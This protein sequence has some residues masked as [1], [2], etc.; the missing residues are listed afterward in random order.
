MRF[1]RTKFLLNL[2]TLLLTPLLITFISK[3]AQ[4]EQVFSWS[5]GQNPTYMMDSNDG[6]CF[7][8]SVQGKFEG[9]GE[10][11]QVY[12]DSN[13]WFLGGTSRAVGVRGQATCV[14]WAEVGATREN[15]DGPY[16]WRQRQAGV[17]MTPVD[18]SVCF[19]SGVSGKFEGSGEFLQ[20]YN[21]NV[22]W[23]LG[24][25]SLQQGLNARAYCI[26]SL[27]TRSRLTSQ[28]YWW[29]GQEPV[30]MS[31]ADKGTCFLTQMTGEFEGRGDRIRIY[32]VE[33]FRTYA[34]TERQSCALTLVNR[35]VS[36]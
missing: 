30:A 15:L 35:K 7:L 11:V 20:I 10:S 34:L 22:N 29:R 17:R 4:A 6:V 33:N 9:R 18:S 5:Q 14:S 12:L 19:L 13:Q 1:Q 24:G 2:T 8:R 21:D 31:Y 26:N 36:H 23:R 28:S 3:S 32:Q 25:A 16:Y 27:E